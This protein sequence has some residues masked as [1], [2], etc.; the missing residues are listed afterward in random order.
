MMGHE[1]CFNGEIGLMIPKSLL[2][3]R[4]TLS[5]VM[6][7]PLSA[8]AVTVYITE[9]RTKYRREMNLLDNATNAKAVDSLLNFE[10]VSS[11]HVITPEKLQLKYCLTIYGMSLVR[12]QRCFPSK[13][14]SGSRSFL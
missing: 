8:S 14:I 7:L 3:P 4:L 11:A 5:T 2:L 10:T 9:W 6:H 1:I 12:R 13:T